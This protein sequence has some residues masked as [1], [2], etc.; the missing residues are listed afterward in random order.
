MISFRHLLGPYSGRVLCGPVRNNYSISQQFESTS[1]QPIDGE[2]KSPTKTSD[3]KA[4]V[5]KQDNSSDVPIKYRD[6][7]ALQDYD[8]P[9]DDA[10]VPK[11]HIF[12]QINTVKLANPIYTLD[13]ASIWEYPDTKTRSYK[14]PTLS[15][16]LGNMEYSHR[17]YDNDYSFISQFP[18]LSDVVIVG[19]GLI[20][21]ATA[22][23]A[24]R[25]VSRCFDIL[26]IDKEP[27]SP[28]NTTAF[29]NGLLSC[30]SKS[31]D[32]SRLAT[33]SKELIRN[34]KR[35][36]LV[37]DEDFAQVKYRPCTHLVL[38]SEAD[39]DEAYEATVTQIQDGCF[40]EAKLP[41][42]LETAFPFLK[43]KNTDVTMGTH[44]LQE[45]AIYDPIGLRNLYRTLGQGYGANYI[46]AEFVDFNTQHNYLVDY[47]HE[48][49]AGSLAAKMT[50]GE[51]SATFFN[52]T[53]LCNGHSMPF[54]EALS[55][56]EPEY[57][58]S[59]QDLH[60]IQ[61]KLRICLVF[62]SFAAPV[63]NFPVITDTDGTMLMRDDYAGSF[64]YYLPLEESEK[65]FYEDN[66]RFMD[67]TSTDP[68]VNLIHK[69]E[70]FENYFNEIV[71][72]RLVKRI[73]VMEDAKLILAQSGFESYN[74]F[75]GNPILS[76]HPYHEKVILSG[77][78]GN[79]LSQ[80]APAAG[81]ILAELSIYHET[82]T[83][84]CSDLSWNRVLKGR[85]L[86]EFSALQ[87]RGSFEKALAVTNQSRMEQTQR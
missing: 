61:P 18:D 11:K 36:V 60:F 10:E 77:A 6:E 49:S 4:T 23:Y 81:C 19:G 59:I 42:E 3:P 16:H 27:Y 39:A 41:D 2:N 84:D 29:S 75:D 40:T 65:L 37:T 22:Y 79:R 31:R 64:K 73:P 5:R 68:Y 66:S 50:N 78:Y 25:M 56:M 55:E 63:I 13:H 45:E 62:S 30:Q 9:Q 53:V 54:L 20:G 12:Q 28:H 86:D 58:D 32:I 80:L 35:D 15:N 52:K 33:L 67:V 17:S 83:F 21:A 71:K 87:G 44:G 72:P 24:K 8:I 74:T 14:Y 34:L 70:R 69:P 38:W 1:S 85:T 57:R 48:L 26:V 7:T 43:V 51:L 46:Q 76:N 82:Q 47:I